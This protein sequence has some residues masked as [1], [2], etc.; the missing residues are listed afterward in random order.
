MSLGGMKQ[1]KKGKEKMYILFEIALVIISYDVHFYYF[2]RLLHTKW[3]Y[4]YHKK[5]HEHVEL[6]LNTTWHADFLENT[7]SGIGAFYPFVFY[8]H[9][10]M[11]GCLTGAVLCFINGCIHHSPYLVKLPILHLW[12]GDEHH[13]NHHRYFNCNYGNFYLDYLHGTERKVKM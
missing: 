11:V 5:H 2:H 13:I 7:V 9:V 8:P 4:P 10:S 12:Y 6:S 1:K 3:M